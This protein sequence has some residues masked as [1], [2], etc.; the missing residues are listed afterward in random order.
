MTIREILKLVEGYC[1]ANVIGDLETALTKYV[2][3]Q[4]ASYSRAHETADEMTARHKAE[5]E[6]W[7]AAR[8]GK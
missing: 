2:Q 4:I 6:A 8:A 3:A 5:D 1:P 7:K